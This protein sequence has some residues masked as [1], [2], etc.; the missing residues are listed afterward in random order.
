MLSKIGCGI[1]TLKITK[2]FTG[3]IHVEGDVDVLVR[4]LKCLS[5]S[6]GESD[7]ISDTLRILNNFDVFYSMLKRKFKDYIAPRK[8]ERDLI[9]G[10]V[11]VDKVKLIRNAERRAIIVLDKRVSQRAI[12]NL[13]KEMNLE[14][15]ASNI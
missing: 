4:F 15:E 13:L 5:K 6:F 7:D 12:I 10:K 8:S 1:V 14:F 9:L 2:D 3:Y 11:V